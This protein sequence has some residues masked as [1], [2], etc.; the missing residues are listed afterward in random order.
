LR[1]RR[2][3]E[4]TDT[5]AVAAR[6]VALQN[7]VRVAEVIGPARDDARDAAGVE[8]VGRGDAEH[9]LDA[10]VIG[11]EAAAREDGREAEVAAPG[12]EY[13]VRRAVAGAGVDDG[14]AADGAAR[15]DGDAHVAERQRH[16]L[17]AVHRLVRDGGAASEAAATV[18]V[19]LFEHQD[20]AAA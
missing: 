1:A 9:A 4:A 12:V 2:T 19:A 6:G 8:R 14:A 18:V 3:A 16:A 20:R 17:V 7:T 5:L 13:A 10:L 11:G 15:E